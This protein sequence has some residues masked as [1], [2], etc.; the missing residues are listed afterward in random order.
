MA[1]LTS[2][3]YVLIRAKL[4]IEPLD[5]LHTW[6]AAR[7]PYEAMAR[8]LFMETGVPI[9]GATVQRWLRAASVAS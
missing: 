5:Q 1:D 3:K 7:V 9:T 4:G 2:D 8:L 6:D